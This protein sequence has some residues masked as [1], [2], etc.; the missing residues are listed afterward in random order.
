MG[1]ICRHAERLSAIIEDL[2]AL[3]RVEQ[4][5]ENAEIRLRPHGVRPVLAA[6]IEV[7]DAKA[8]A[9]GVV[10]TL[11]CDA[12][13]KTRMSPELLEQAVT[14]LIDN[15]VKY[16][17]GDSSVEVEA[18]RADAEVRIRVRDYG[19]G[20]SREHLARL[21]ERFY[22]VDKA[23]SRALGGTGLGL[24]IV[25]H[26]MQTHGGRVSVESS[27]GRGS[28]F[29]LHLPTDTEDRARSAVGD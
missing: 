4:D 20:I 22:R 18:E 17:P 10:V 5:A 23:R 29:T 14:N 26:I 6:A 16:S 12:S 27:P 2:L 19:C 21:F 3:S 15:A 28:V 13:L 8:K 9:K 7:C 1:I 25:K 11:G 24:A